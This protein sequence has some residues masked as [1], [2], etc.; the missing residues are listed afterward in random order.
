MRRFSLP[1][2]LPRLRD[3]R[4]SLSMELV[5]VLPLLLW[6]LTMTVVAYDGFRSRTQAQMAAQTV[7][8]LLS[9][10]TEMFTANYLE[11]MNDVFDFLADTRRP[12]RLRV[13]SVIWDSAEGRPRL[14]WSYG[15]R[16]LAPLPDQVFALLQQG[17]ME[18]L[19]ALMAGVNDTVN[20]VVNGVNDTVNGVTGG[21]LGAG[22]GGAVGGVVDGVG[23]TLGQVT[24]TAGNLTSGITSSLTVQPPVADLIDRIP[25][26]LPGEAMILVETFA[27]WTPFANVG[28]GQIRFAPVVVTRP[29]F[30]PW[31]N[32][33]GAVPVFPEADYELASLGYV[34]GN[35]TLPQPG[36]PD[37][38]PPDPTPITNP[39][40]VVQQTFAAG[41]T[42]GWSQNIT[43]TNAVAGSFLGPF[44][45]AT[46]AAPVTRPL[47]LPL[48]TAR[49]EVA[50]DLLILDTW[51]GFH[52]TWSDTTMGDVMILMIDGQPISTEAFRAWGDGFYA[53]DR[54]N[55]VVIGTTT[56]TVSMT[57]TQS[58]SSFAGGSSN[59]QR[60]RVTLHAEAP[61]STF[62]LGFS[63]RL[64]EG[65]DDESFGIAAFG[66]T[67]MPGTPQPAVFSPDAATLLGT[68]PNT[69]FPIY[70]GCPDPRIGA[71]P[72]SLHLSDLAVTT[73]APIANPG[74]AE[75]W[76]GQNGTTYA[77][78]VTGRASGS[79]SGSIWGTDTYTD[80][81]TIATAAVHA[82][83][84]TH[85]ETGVVLLTV[86]PGQSSYSSTR[87]NGVTSQA[88]GWWNGSY[89]LQRGATPDPANAWSLIR[90]ASGGTQL[91][92]CPGRSG[93]ARFHA[94]ATYVLHW[95]NGGL[96]GSGNQLRLR[97]EDSNNGR[98]C[99]SA[100][101]IRD[102]FGQWHYND[103]TSGSNYNARLN[104]GNASTG[105][106]HVW[107]GT[108][109]GN[110][111]TSTLHF[112]R[113]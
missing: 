103:D 13:S 105:T 113:Y 72:L 71:A 110:T 14:Q 66:V 49:A 107:I 42:A 79:G 19:T 99:D 25:P 81:S 1:S 9:R 40:V 16:G 22:L 74:T 111:C 35:N 68:N 8:D 54:T 83:V 100:L 98:T 108:F 28:V 45:N 112:E 63:A 24:Q 11:G 6:G 78:N 12:T 96:T 93:S 94:A 26:I 27:I 85:G 34:P 59:D 92:G 47:T 62:T 31:V 84:L 52:P 44:G 2:R 18:T 39:T 106:Y 95:N 101:L 33:E 87:R 10:R 21:L 4:G 75:A 104:M 102:P 5:L 17:D 50:F 58:G 20:G 36:D 76:R 88:W 69:R 32:M 64:S 61:P 90:Q 37:P 97:M 77:I 48:G 65:V 46:L 51:D 91:S 7:G 109:A 89:R 43:Q 15:T 56:W 73:G 55:T 53:R 60:W 38:V 70:G 86:Q 29:R 67:A 23:N 82:G 30:T 41:D 3:E 57:R 80:D